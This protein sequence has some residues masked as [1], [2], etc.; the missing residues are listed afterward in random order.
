[1]DV[2]CVSSVGS[3]RIVVSSVS[4]VNFIVLLVCWWC[5]WND[6][7]MEISVV[8]IIVVDSVRVNSRYGCV[9]CMV[10]LLLLGM[11]MLVIIRMVSMKV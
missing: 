3:S 7:M 9:V 8:S 10:W 6:S 5:S 11:F 2:V 4:N 1:M